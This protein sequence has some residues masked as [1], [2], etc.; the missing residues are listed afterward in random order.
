MPTYKVTLVRRT[1]DYCD[2]EVEA[3]DEWDARDKAMDIGCAGD[4]DWRDEDVDEM[5]PKEPELLEPYDPRNE[6]DH[7]A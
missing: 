3:E 5:Y 1:F 6:P 2:V 7:E 4:C